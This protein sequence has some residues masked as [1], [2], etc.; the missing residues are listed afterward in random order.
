MISKDRHFL[1]IIIFIFLFTICFFVYFNGLN[2]EFILDDR[3]LVVDN[4]DIKNVHRLSNIFKKDIFYFQ[5]LEDVSQGEYYR[6]LQSLSYALDYSVWGLKPIGYRLT[7]ILI[8]SFNSWLVFFIIFLIFK[9]RM[10]AVLTSIFF[11]V[12]PMQVCLITFIAGRSNLLET[13]F[14]LLSLVSFIFY[15]RN[16]KKYCYAVSIVFFVA[17]LFSR[18][19]ALLLPLFLVLSASMVK[20]RKREIFWAVLPY[21]LI[22]AFY[23]VFRGSFIPL[24]YL[25][26]LG[27]G[28]SIKKAVT[29]TW[30]WFGYFR[31]LILPV[32]FEKIIFG[33]SAFVAFAVTCIAFI[34]FL[35]SLIRVVIYKDKVCAFALGI[36]LI[37][38]MPVI[39]LMNNIFEFGVIL[40]QHYIYISSIGFCLFLS[41]LLLKIY[42]RFPKVGKVLVFTGVF[43]FVVLTVINNN[44]YKDEI[45]FYEHVL[46]VD[47]NNS[48]VRVNLGTAY[49]EKKMYDKAIEQVRF[50]LAADP[51]RW[52]NYL[53]LGNIMKEKG[54]FDQAKEAYKKSLILYPQ[55][56]EV[57]NNLGLVYAMEGE[58]AKAL[59]AFKKA[60]SINSETA[61]ALKNLAD[62]LFEIKSYETALE[63]YGK[64]LD[65]DPNDWDSYCRVGIILAEMNR[66]KEA[67][68]FLKQALT[69]NPGAIEAKRNLGNLYANNGK[70]DEA[71]LIWRQALVINPQDRDIKDR[72][73]QA[74]ALMRNI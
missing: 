2:N 26:F 69:L 1:N 61:K 22:A 12:H 18:E 5:H 19:G 57:F 44:Y 42:A 45:A 14:M 49:Y 72:I 66:Y 54:D 20:L 28:F 64:V 15:M 41:Y 58:A 24:R 25:S 8:H 17:A 4:T 70:L 53:L 10:A 13:L 23:M 68:F 62:F 74:Q 3:F 40:S 31:Q 59:D 35:Y 71:I 32:E 73:E 60:V 11:C 16:R 30:I 38:L 51:Y 33:D 46:N 65:I 21:L 29:S 34:G 9:N 27:D 37:G 39:K 55:A 7:N 63:Y 36:Y 50:L 56:W 52:D 6:P 43:Y 47:R 48:F 67:E